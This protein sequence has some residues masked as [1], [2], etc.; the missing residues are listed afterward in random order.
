[1]LLPV[2]AWAALTGLTIIR[3]GAPLPVDIIA[4]VVAFLGLFVF[5]CAFAIVRKFTYDF[6]VPIQFLRGTTC[7]AAWH[8]ALDLI[9]DH[10]GEV[11]LY[12]LFSI[13]LSIG[14]SL[15]VIA[16]MLLTCCTA[17][18]LF[19]IPFIGTVAILPLLVFRR[20]YSAYY[21]AQFGSPYDV[22]AA[23]ERPN[24]A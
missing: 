7:L 4:L 12:L 23:P 1:L 5:S 6:I 8:E 10:L 14:I 20:A 17:C 3:Q 21:L 9:G 16:V 13:V 24:P 18:C 2:L 22:F 11:I 15:L 19:A